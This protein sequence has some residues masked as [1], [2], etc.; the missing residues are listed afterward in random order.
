MALGIC[1]DEGDEAADHDL[2]L[3]PGLDV[4]DQAG[5]S[6]ANDA[7]FEADNLTTPHRAAEEHAVD[8]QADDVFRVGQAGGGDEARFDE[9]FGGAPGIERAVVVQVFAF[10]KVVGNISGDFH[11]K[12]IQ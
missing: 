7:A 8:L 9:P 3:D 10:D 6:G 1:V 11:T 12:I 2:V 4:G 5:F